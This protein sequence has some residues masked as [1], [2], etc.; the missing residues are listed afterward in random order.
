M[1]G[2]AATANETIAAIM[3][4][5]APAPRRTRLRLRIDEKPHF[6]RLPLGVS[7]NKHQ[8][9]AIVEG[10]RDGRDKP[11]HDAPGDPFRCGRRF[12]NWAEAVKASAQRERD[13]RDPAAESLRSELGGRLRRL[14]ETMRDES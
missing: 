9:R 7:A 1:S 8:S 12:A 11:G 6:P 10:S 5:N 4:A 2:E 3:A 13:E 14:A